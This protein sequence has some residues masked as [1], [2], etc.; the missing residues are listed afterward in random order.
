MVVFT[1]VVRFMV[2]AVLTLMTIVSPVKM[3][4]KTAANEPIDPENCK[5]SLAVIS[6]THMKVEAGGILNDLV[7]HLVMK[8]FEAKDNK[9]DALIFAGD[10][11]DHGYEEQWAHLNEQIKNYEPAENIYLA[12][13]NHDTWT[14]DET[15]KRTAKGLFME[16][17]TKITEKRTLNYY[18]STTVNGYP[19]I[20]LTS[21]DDHTAA[22]F[23]DKQ[24]KWFKNAMKKAAKLDKPIFV[25]C[26]WPI[27]M[28]HG[29]PVSWGDD[30]YDDMTGGMGEQSDRINKI[31]QKYDNVFMISGHIHNGISNS[32]TKAELGYES[33]EKVGNIYSLNIPAINGFNENG[34]WF[35]GTSYV[36]EV[37]EDEV[38]FR[39]RNFMSGFWRPEYNYSVELTK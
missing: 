2:A 17:S 35:P 32:E 28:T 27:N 38:V 5:L 8:D 3:A 22:T 21:E 33:L 13:G 15:G 23:S 7:F 19:L 18:Y 1:S 30:D 39:A 26:H 10:I 36:I 37:Y 31:M 14:R 12:M 24:I 11:T 29:L 25:V 9:H 20:V 4:D 16:Y 34:D 6:D